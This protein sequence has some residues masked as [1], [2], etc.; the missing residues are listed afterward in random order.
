MSEE[1]N[2]PHASLRIFKANDAE[3]RWRSI[4][5]YKCSPEGWSI[6][7]RAPMGIGSFGLRD[8][9]DFIIANAT[10]SLEDLREIRDALD[11]KIRE[12]EARGC[13]G[14]TET[15]SGE[16]GDE[17]REASVTTPEQPLDPADLSGRSGP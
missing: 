13:C 16:H 10:C 8:G 9:R 17:C 2:K 12:A 14:E 5:I 4:R 15:G 6:Q 3:E 7:L 1:F 11:A